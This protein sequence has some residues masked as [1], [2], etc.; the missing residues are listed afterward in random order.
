MGKPKRFGDI[1]VEEHFEHEKR[2]WRRNGEI[3]IVPK[4]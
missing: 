2:E 4:S 3:S 1:E